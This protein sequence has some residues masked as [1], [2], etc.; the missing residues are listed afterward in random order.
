[1]DTMTLT[2]PGS[3]AP[4]APEATGQP[5]RRPTDAPPPAGA[6]RG[7]SRLRRVWRGADSDPRWARPALL[8]L[9]LVTLVLYT[10]NLPASGYANS[11]YSAAVQAGSDSWKA[12]FYGRS[13]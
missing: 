5:G 6:G 11:F 4:A 12:F 10:W 2:S 3:S 8:G 13:D 9:L 7:T 1:M